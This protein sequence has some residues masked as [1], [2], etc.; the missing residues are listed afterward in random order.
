[1][2]HFGFSTNLILTLGLI[3]DFI[4]LF[5]LTKI[6]EEP[7]SVLH[8]TRVV[9]KMPYLRIAFLISIILSYGCLPISRQRFSYITS[10]IAGG[11][12]KISWFAAIPSFMNFVK[13]SVKFVTYCSTESPRGSMSSKTA[14]LE[15]SKMTAAAMLPLG[16]LSH[17]RTLGR[18]SLLNAVV[19]PLNPRLRTSHFLLE[20]VS[21]SVPKRSV[22]RSVVNLGKI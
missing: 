14:S 15:P 2:I 6:K 18:I 5:I 3:G 19:Y 12:S 17:W 22:F 10:D 16:L 21:L 8:L 4:S 9:V 20:I 11:V 1:M 7:N 13:M